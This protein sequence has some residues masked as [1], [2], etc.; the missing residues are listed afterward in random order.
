MSPVQPRVSLADRLRVEVRAVRSR[1][2]LL[3]RLSIAGNL[4]RDF[5][6]IADRLQRIVDALD[7]EG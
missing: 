5:R 7:T 3:E 4:Y 1:A 2:D 6:E